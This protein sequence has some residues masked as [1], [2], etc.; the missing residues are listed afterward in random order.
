MSWTD[1]LR[2]QFALARGKVLVMVQDGRPARARELAL[3]LAPLTPKLYVCDD[4]EVLVAAPEGATLVLLVRPDWAPWLNANRPIFARMRW[5]A[6]LWVEPGDTARLMSAAPDFMDW[7]SHVTVCPAGAPRFACL[8]L[9]AHEDEVGVRWVGEGLEEALAAWRPGL[10]ARTLTM[11]R[12]HASLVRS[13]ERYRDVPIVMRDVASASEATRLRWALAEAR[14]PGLCV[15]ADSSHDVPGF[16]VIKDQS[17]LPWGDAA[18]RLRAAGAPE[19]GLLAAVL[20]LEP[21]AV[22]LACRLSEEVGWD[23]VVRG[24]TGVPDPGAELGRLAHER[25]KDEAPGSGSS[26]A[27]RGVSRPVSDERVQRFHDGIIPTLAA[28]DVA[29]DLWS[30]YQSAS[31][32]DDDPVAVSWA[33]Q[34]PGP[35]ALPRRFIPWVPGALVVEASL[36]CPGLTSKHARQVAAIW[37]RRLWQPDVAASWCERLEVLEQAERDGWGEELRFGLKLIESGE[38]SVARKVLA[39][40]PPGP[41]EPGVALEIAA[42]LLD[43]EPRLALE[44]V[45]HN[46]AQG[47]IGGEEREVFLRAWARKA[48]YELLFSWMP[49]P[50]GEIAHMLRGAFSPAEWSDLMARAFGM[51]ESAAAG[52]ELAIQWLRDHR[53][54]L[55]LPG[56]LARARPELRVRWHALA[57][58]LGVSRPLT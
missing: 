50:A 57:D 44:W 4:L 55:E 48:E 23:V 35:V 29:P 28:A 20:D 42:A 51:P 6:V 26:C 5:R 56:V 40:I 27:R 13:L 11:R 49:D 52:V 16:E 9:S 24:I 22:D 7:I 37:A 47:P 34:P 33:S 19:P 39:S 46:L 30:A 25:R 10:E 21:E 32:V 8:N 58:Q 18:R 17:P 14:Y 43:S 45:F 1:P 2:R 31:A 53:R 54:L 38:L 12:T 41:V 36:R 15:V 3:A